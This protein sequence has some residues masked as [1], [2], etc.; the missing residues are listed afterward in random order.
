MTP[1]ARARRRSRSLR[2]CMIL[3]RALAHPDAEHELAFV[4][5][6]R[7]LQSLRCSVGGQPLELHH[8]DLDGVGIEGDALAVHDQ[9][10]RPRRRQRASQLVELL[11]Q[12]VTRLLVTRVRPEQGHQRLA[13]V[14]G[15]G[16]QGEE[17]QQ[18]LPL[19]A[20]HRDPRSRVRLHP[21]TAEKKDFQP[22]HAGPP[23]PGI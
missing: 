1:M 20:R 14:A 23:V 16:P 21:E 15:P 22:R 8:V 4:Q 17:R 9:G 12:A 11:P 3:E 6:G 7:A 19:L 2:R 18:R 5:T 13:R 10:A